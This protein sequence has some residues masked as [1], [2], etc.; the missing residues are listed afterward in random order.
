MTGPKAAVDNAECECECIFVHMVNTVKA[1]GCCKYRK[2]R[3]RC[4]L[5]NCVNR[6]NDRDVA[7]GSSTTEGRQGGKD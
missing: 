6:M 1:E 5:V 4:A 3:G 2:R 7:E